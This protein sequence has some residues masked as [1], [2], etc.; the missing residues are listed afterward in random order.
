MLLENTL[1]RLFLK[2]RTMRLTNQHAEIN[3]TAPLFIQIA[4]Q[5]CL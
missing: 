4:H 5:Y 2:E 3:K 1:C